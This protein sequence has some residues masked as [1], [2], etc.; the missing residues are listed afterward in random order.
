MP[1]IDLTD[2]ARE[3]IERAADGEGIRTLRVVITDT[4]EHRMHFDEPTAAD[5]SIPF[6]SI[7]VVMD[8][9]SASRADG[10]SID[11]VLRAEG[12]GFVVTNPNE[13][14]VRQ[15]TAHELKVLIESAREF[16]LV[17]VRTEQERAIARIDGSRLLDERSYEELVA[18]DRNTPLVFQCHHGIRSQ[19]A[20]E[21]FLREGFRNVYNLEGGID[22]WSTMVDPRVARY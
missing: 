9:V 7:A 21:H 16:V 4:F 18:L 11:Y 14:R 20:A 19:A 1:S 8:P 13:P 3:A 15:M 2:S 12:A 10:L 6:G 17:D 5:V 22:A